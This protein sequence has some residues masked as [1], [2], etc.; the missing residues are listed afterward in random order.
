MQC[1]Q[2][3]AARSSLACLLRIPEV[4]AHVSTCPATPRFKLKLKRIQPVHNLPHKSARVVADVPKV[5][6]LFFN[7]STQTLM[8]LAL[9]DAKSTGLRSEVS[10]KLQL[11][12]AV[13]LFVTGRCPPKRAFLEQS[14]PSRL[15]PSKT[16][17]KITEGSKAPQTPD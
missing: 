4:R 12:T 1:L 15:S 17:S 7:G 8:D 16:R 3:S 14:D 5:L 9:A 6:D 2:S 10:S 11:Q 13:K